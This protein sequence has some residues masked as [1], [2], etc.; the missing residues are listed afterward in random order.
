M[1]NPKKLSFG[2]VVAFI[3]LLPALGFSFLYAWLRIDETPLDYSS[4]DVALAPTDP[5]INGYTLLRE[6]SAT[7]DDSDNTLDEL[8]L[9]LEQPTSETTADDLSAHIDE[10]QT[11]LQIIDKAFK[12]PVF[13][14]DLPS[15]PETIISEFS[16]IQIYTALRI[17]ESR[18][19]TMEGD[20]ELALSEL[21]E[22]HSQIARYTR[23]G[24]P[25]I[26]LLIG[27]RASDL[28]EQEL[29]TFVANA[30]LSAETWK[31][32]TQAYQMQETYSVA[33]SNAFKQE[34]QFADHC[35]E[36]MINDPAAIIELTETE[37]TSNSTRTAL[38]YA[39]PFFFKPNRTKNMIYRSYSEIAEQA[40]LALQ[41]RKLDYSTL[42][43]E[44]TED[45]DKMTVFSRNAFGT[46]FIAMIVPTH[47][48]IFEAVC[49]QQA[50]EAATQLSFSLKGY[51][52]ENSELPPTLNQLVPRYIEAIP[53]DPFDGKPMRYSKDR[54]IIYSVGN[55]FIDDGGSLRPFRFTQEDTRINADVAEKDKSEPTFPLRFAM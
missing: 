37:I 26:P 38:G 32:A 7:R 22:S 43:I 33:T 15:T 20:E 16:D 35:L 4:L 10:N 27:I 41:Q 34:F 3:L 40:D 17:L 47:E 42:L 51:F 2:V 9:L 53:A 52:Q 11:L 12:R 48:A 5:E 28:I 49:K 31:S 13:V 50:A 19:L 54:A 30:T 44:T 18:R 45:E 29:S 23:S 39:A 6:F 46:I 14:F 1:R 8:K 25:L 55:D 36:L 21:L 24:G